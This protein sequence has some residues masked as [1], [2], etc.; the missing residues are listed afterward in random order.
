MAFLNAMAR[1]VDFEKLKAE[2]VELEPKGPR[3]GHKTPFVFEPMRRKMHV[4]GSDQ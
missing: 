4:P 3:G 2:A 1:E